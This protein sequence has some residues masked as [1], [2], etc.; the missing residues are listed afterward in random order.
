VIMAAVS[1]S[2]GN[3]FREEFKDLVYNAID[4]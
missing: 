4:D 1:P 3:G 2:R